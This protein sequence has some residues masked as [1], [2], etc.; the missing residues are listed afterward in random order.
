MRN[1]IKICVVLIG[2]AS[3][4]TNVLRESTSTGAQQIHFSS[5]KPPLKSK[6]CM[7]CHPAICEKFENAPHTR[8][9]FR[10]NDPEML[11][12]YA[13]KEFNFEDRGITTKFFEKDNDLYIESNAFPKPIKVDYVFGSG[14]HAQTLV[15]IYNYPNGETRMMTH[16]VSW[17]PS[18]KV[19]VT[20]GMET[21]DKETGRKAICDFSE[22]TTVRS[23]FGCHLTHIPVEENK[24]IFE[25]MEMGISCERCHQHGEKHIYEAENGLPFSRPPIA[26]KSPLESI[27]QCGE[28][29]RRADQLTKDEIDPNREE[30]N[31]FAPV[32]ISQSACFIHQGENPPKDRRLDC[33]TCHDPHSPAVRNDQFYNDKCLNCH[34]TKP[35]QSALCSKESMT[36]NCIH[37]HLPSVQVQKNLA[38]T[39][40]WIRIRPEI[41]LDEEKKKDE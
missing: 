8:T 17:Y 18:G 30:L 1:L 4:A 32:G 11:K 22:M 40:H 25:K 9:L 2:V 36:S 38:F 7:D 13:G 16:Q 35:D 20:L 37:C 31:R 21:H 23:C 19:D 12:R 28:C 10:A 24:L 29:H 34:G 41:T 27:N 6:S 26:K 5:S 33:V 3:I 15:S 14:T 39:D